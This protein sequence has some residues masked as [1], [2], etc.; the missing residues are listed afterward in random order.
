MDT[1]VLCVRSGGVI[2]VRLEE[3]IAQ[4]QLCEVGMILGHIHILCMK[5]VRVNESTCEITGR[6]MSRSDV[7]EI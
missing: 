6:N 3:R 2:G 5:Y 1:M 7:P 4:I